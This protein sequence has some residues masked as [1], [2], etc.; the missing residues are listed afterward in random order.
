MNEQ[1]VSYS[2][3]FKF[4]H[5]LIALV[6]ILMLVGSYFLEDLPAQYRG[7]AFML[8]KSVGIS[9]LFLMLFRL[10]WVWRK[11]K[12]SLPVSVPLWQ[13]I[14]SR[15]VQYALYFFLIAMPLCGWIM[16][17]AS[18]KAPYF[19]GLFQL[20]L[21][22]IE[23]NQALSHLMKETHNTIAWVIIVL[24]ALHI[25]GAIKHHFIDKDKVVQRMLK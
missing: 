22:G 21:P 23:P 4:L 16:A 5:W 7:T 19:F 3:G 24:I 6:V 2:G 13:R 9:V 20:G 10:V 12:P 11:G 15:T 14:L 8:H 1:E 25:A 18:N 17:V